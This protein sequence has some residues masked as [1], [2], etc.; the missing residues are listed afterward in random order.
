MIAE[1]IIE[2][3]RTM[4]LAL[5]IAM[6][7]C[8]IFIAM[9]RWFAAPFVWLSIFGVIGLLVYGIV[10]TYRKYIYLKNNPVERPP[11]TTNISAF[12]EQYLVLKVRYL[13]L[14]H[15]VV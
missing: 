12:F 3:W 14:C 10:E 1:D 9:M 13:N 2:T 8:L 6:I 15:S 5:A 11:A 7:V 4:A